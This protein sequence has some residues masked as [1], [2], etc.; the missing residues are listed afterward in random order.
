[1]NVANYIL[2]IAIAINNRTCNKAIAAISPNPQLA[3][4]CFAFCLLSLGMAEK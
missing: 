4:Y 1:M 3:S 2:G